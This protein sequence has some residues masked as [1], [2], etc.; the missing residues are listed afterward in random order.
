M[1]FD[2]ADE[3]NLTDVHFFDFT[4]KE[5]VLTAVPKWNVALETG[6]I[7]TVNLTCACKYFQYTLLKIFEG[8]SSDT[9]LLL[10]GIMIKK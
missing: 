2:C 4:I 3:S 1:Q 5:I 9:M 8:L 7:V 10:L 6:L